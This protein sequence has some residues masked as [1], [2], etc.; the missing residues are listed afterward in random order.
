MQNEKRENRI[1]EMHWEEEKSSGAERMSST[2][3]VLQIKPDES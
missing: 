3:P 2:C 1:R